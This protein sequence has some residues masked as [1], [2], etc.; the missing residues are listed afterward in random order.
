MGM[1]GRLYYPVNKYDRFNCMFFIKGGSNTG[2]KF[3]RPPLQVT[4][5]ELNLVSNSIHKKQIR[6]QKRKQKN[7]KIQNNLLKQ[8]NP[9]IISIVFVVSLI[10]SFLFSIQNHK[11]CMIWYILYTNKI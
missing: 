3:T 8:I 9:C 1:I 4:A 10:D 6:K 11:G 5:L 7:K 2:E